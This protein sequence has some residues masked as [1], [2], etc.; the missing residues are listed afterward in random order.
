[1]EDAQNQL[2]DLLQGYDDEKVVINQALD[3][4]SDAFNVNLDKI[5]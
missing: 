4:A 1:L 5:S 3:E 2:D